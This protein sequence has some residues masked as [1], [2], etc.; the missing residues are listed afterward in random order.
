MISGYPVW[1]NCKKIRRENLVTYYP[2]AKIISNF[3]M[4]LLFYY[5]IDLWMIYHKL[6]LLEQNYESVRTFY[7]RFICSYTDIRN[8]D[9]IFINTGNIR[10]HSGGSIQNCAKAFIL[11]YGRMWML[12]ALIDKIGVWRLWRISQRDKCGTMPKD[13]SKTYRRYD[14]AHNSALSP[15]TIHHTKWT[16]QKLYRL[17]IVTMV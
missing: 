7:S 4:K 10:K 1:N 2:M 8:M 15:I 6:E 11:G 16:K 3:F 14:G 17:H 13:C 5:H 12:A 9:S